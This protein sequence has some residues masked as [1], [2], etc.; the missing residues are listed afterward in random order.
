[1]VNPNY[2]NSVR[3]DRAA[4]MASRDLV[5]VHFGADGRINATCYD[6]GCEVTLK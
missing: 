2:L 5:K 1:V 4:A 6:D 3:Q